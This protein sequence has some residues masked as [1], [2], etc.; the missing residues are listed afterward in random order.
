MATQTRSFRLRDDLLRR[1]GEKGAEL[2]MSGSA[3]AARYIEEGLRLED[4]PSIAFF[5]RA[6]GRRAMVAGTRLNVSDVVAAAKAAGSAEGA[7]EALDL[8]L[9]KVRAALSYYADF[10]DEID[11]EIE[12]D[13]R[14]AGREEARWRAEQSALA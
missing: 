6:S 8:A 5:T 4:H 7:A 9:P 10:R 1:L 3:L 2:G 14:T 13:L 11:A 12:R